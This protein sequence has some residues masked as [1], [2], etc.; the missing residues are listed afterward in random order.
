MRWI[1]AIVL[2]SIIVL[3]VLLLLDRCSVT[4]EE[5]NNRANANTQAGNYTTAIAIYQAIQID[6]PDRG[7]FYFNAAAAYADANQLTNAIAA[8]E[9]AERRG[10][11]AL[12][13]DALYN[14]GNL[15]F[16]DEDYESA[17][18]VYQQTLLIE[19]DNEDA[20]WN[21]ELAIG[22]IPTPTP[23]PQEMQTSPDEE[24]VEPTPTPNPA[25]EDAP[26]PTPTPPTELPPPNE[27]E[28]P[29]ETSANETEEA[30][31]EPQATEST[32]AEDEELEQGEAEQLLDPVQANQQRL[33]TFEN[34]L[35]LTGTPP[36]I[37]RDW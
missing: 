8:L 32:I 23:T 11:D 19:P 1:R 18:A 15:Y 28:E 3:I 5:Q 10:D 37:E 24:Q 35:Q 22:Q 34:D 2:L 36:P 26:T 27:N 31:D 12:R 9:Q 29:T 16:D 6:A 14:L 25:G 13:A 21:L 4:I 20:R 7:E 30:T 33:N 17:I